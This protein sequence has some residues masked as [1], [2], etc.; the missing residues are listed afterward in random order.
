MQ[1]I[2]LLQEFAC[3]KILYALKDNVDDSKVTYFFR[4]T[5]LVLYL[6]LTHSNL[7]CKEQSLLPPRGPYASLKRLSFA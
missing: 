3:G 2:V 4:Y 7:L 6:L 1:Y 5:T